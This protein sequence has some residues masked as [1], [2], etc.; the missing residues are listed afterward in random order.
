MRLIDNEEGH[1]FSLP[2]ENVIL[3]APRRI[4]KQL[5]TFLKFMPPP[6][7]RSRSFVVHDADGDTQ[8]L[9]Y[10]ETAAGWRRQL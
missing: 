2:P 9:V 5:H 6:P 8:T 4:S 10:V 3:L 1:L 7:P